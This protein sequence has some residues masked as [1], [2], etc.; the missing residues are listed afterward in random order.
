MQA[1]FYGYVRSWK[2]TLV[3]LILL[4][5]VSGPV[6]MFDTVFGNRYIAD[7][8]NLLAMPICPLC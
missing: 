2:R 7:P 3:M 5:L 1:G 8:N 4:H 6:Y